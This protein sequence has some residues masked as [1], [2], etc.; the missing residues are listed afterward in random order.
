MLEVMG[1]I[2]YVI[3]VVIVGI[4]LY[5]KTDG[6]MAKVDR[7]TPFVETSTVV[8]YALLAFIL[9][10]FLEGAIL[11]LFHSESLTVTLLALVLGVG[12]IEEGAKLL[13]YLSSRG[14]ELYRWHLT[15]K[16]ALAFAVIEAV[17]YGLVLFFSGNIFGALIRIIVVMF[18][19]A[20]T[21]I[22]LGDALE[23]DAVLGYLKASALHSLYDAPVLLAFA[24]APVLIIAVVSVI[25]LIYT[26]SS[27]DEAFGRAYAKAKRELE[28]RKRKAQEFWA[29]RG[30]EVAGSDLTS[31]L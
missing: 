20:F 14:S 28:E 21:T 29:E 31:S 16:V 6:W 19:V 3:A 7:V 15:V 23:G 30:V 5:F 11:Y 25:A 8:K 12:L 17:L 1:L 26:Y 24:G 22:A 18:H 9:A 2:G 13:P 10:L 4:K 27:V